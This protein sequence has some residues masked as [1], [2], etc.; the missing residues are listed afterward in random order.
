MGLRIIETNLLVVDFLSS[1]GETYEI[2]VTIPEEAEIPQGSELHVVEL[3][4][5]AE[6]ANGK[7]YAD[8]A[9]ELL[10]L[11]EDDVK[12]LKLFDIFITKDDQ[13]I[14]PKVPVTVDI[15]LL[16]KNADLDEK[17]ELGVQVVSFGE[18]ETKEVETETEEDTVSFKTK[19]LDVC[20]FV[21][22]LTTTFLSN[23]GNKYEVTVTYGPEAK[24]PSG[25]KLSV[26]DIKEGTEEYERAR[27]AVLADKKEKG[28]YVN[29]N[30][31]FIVV[32]CNL[33]K[34]NMFNM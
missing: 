28:E 12:Y 9:D 24:I 27:R 3:S 23:D 34:N 2:K 26:T 17:E 30:D 33:V 14:Q 6:N 18:E 16:D 10:E 29:L 8:A 21:G 20:A 25:S 15:S 31:F 5:V 11:E 4:D 13:K 7:K 32:V 19:E 22:T 1:K